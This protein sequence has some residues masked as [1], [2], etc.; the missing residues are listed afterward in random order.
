MTFV[1]TEEP[2]TQ[3]AAFFV[4]VPDFST[5]L[6]IVSPTWSIS[7]IVFSVTE[8]GAIGSTA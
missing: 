7:F 8:F 4:F 3:T 5:T 6:A 2:A 1:I